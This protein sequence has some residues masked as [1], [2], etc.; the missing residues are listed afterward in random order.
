VMTLWWHTTIISSPTSN[1]QL[2][3]QHGDEVLG[4]I[5]DLLRRIM[6][7]K[8]DTRNL[9]KDSSFYEDHKSRPRF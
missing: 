8:K 4:Q 1:F 2:V 6:H 5:N 9:S 7:Y 3:L